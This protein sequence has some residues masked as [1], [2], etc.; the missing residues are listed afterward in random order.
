MASPYRSSSLTL[1]GAAQSV[2]HAS[3]STIVQD[4]GEI[5]INFKAARDDKSLSEDSSYGANSDPRDLDPPHP[6]KQQYTPL[7]FLPKPNADPNLVEWEGP[8]DPENPQNWSFW[9][10]WWLTAVCTLMTL[11]VYVLRLWKLCYHA[12]SLPRHP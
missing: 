11:N 5:A 8:D 10:K 6:K 1:N 3:T 12:C 4:E 7:P 9:Y 2:V